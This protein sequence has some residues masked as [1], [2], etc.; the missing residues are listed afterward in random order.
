MPKSFGYVS[1]Q[2][3]KI[4]ADVIR[5]FKRETYTR[6]NAKP[7]DTILD[8]GCGPGSDTIELASIVGDTGFVYGI[9][10]DEEMIEIAD[11]EAQ[12]AGVSKNVIHQ[13]GTIQNLPFNDNFFDSCRAERLF[14]VIPKN[15]DRN[16]LFSEII[17][18]LKPGGT[19]VLIDTDWGTTSIDFPDEELERRLV[20]FFATKMRPDGFAGRTFRRHF[21]ENGLV[22]IAIENIVLV[23]KK[24]EETPF[25]DWMIGTALNENIITP[26]EADFWKKTLSER[27]LN[28]TFYSSVNTVLMVGKKPL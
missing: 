5:Q 28:N 4:V 1:P 8:L 10:M 14:Q 12:K 20:N 7:G 27:S 23:N 19:L 3:L 25:G 11:N 9:D 18:V 17:R 22:D 13:V 15:I 6:L 26:E 24:I 16:M 21:L 2:Y